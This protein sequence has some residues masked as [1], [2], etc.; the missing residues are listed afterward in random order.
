METRAFAPT[1]TPTT[2]SYAGTLLASTTIAASTSAATNSTPFTGIAFSGLQQ[3]QISN[4]TTAWAYVNFGV[5]GTIIA[6]TVAAGYPVAPG[7]VVV[8]SV[9][10][11]VNAA[12]VIL[13]TG[14]GNVIFT[15]GE[16][17]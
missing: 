1:Y 11:E 6:A 4:T 2:A 15:R 8:V 5:V 10:Q 7:T 3:I 9:A 17:V 14:S 16:G 13:G 12:S